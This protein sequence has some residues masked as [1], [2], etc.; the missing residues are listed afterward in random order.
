MEKDNE[1]II[2]KSSYL[3][4]LLDQLLKLWEQMHNESVGPLFKKPGM[5]LLLKVLKYKVFPF[6]Y[7]PFICHGM[8]CLLLCHS[9]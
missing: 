4:Q 5:G 8:F 9:K 1:S 3:L 2:V 7:Y 6:F